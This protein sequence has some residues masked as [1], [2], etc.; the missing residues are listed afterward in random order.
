MKI[1]KPQNQIL[2]DVNSITKNFKA[3]R[4][5]NEISFQIKEGEFVALLGP[6]GAGKTTL[7]EIIEGLQNP[8]TGSVTIDG[9][10]WEHD[11]K[12]IH[13]I[14][15]LSLQETFFFDRV[16]V[17]ETIKLFA[18]FYH[19]DK[20]RI[21]EVIALIDLNDKLNTYTT[22]LS[23]GQRQRLALGLALLNKPKLLLLDEPTT[24]LDPKARRR[25]WEILKKIKDEK[26]SSLILTTH[27]MEEAEFLCDRVIMLDRGKILMDDTLSNLLSHFSVKNLDDLFMLKTGRHLQESNPESESEGI[28]SKKSKE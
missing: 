18:S 4:A 5:V 22:Q 28:D 11:A 6:N 27:Y 1:N 3:L 7:I 16:T 12:E 14:I 9:K 23:G 21:E 8:D 19:I 24:G 17:L 25:I 20:V 15:G 2:L 13:Q 26:S 10:K